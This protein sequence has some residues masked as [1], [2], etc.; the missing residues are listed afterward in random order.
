MTN[1]HTAPEQLLFVRMGM[2]FHEAR[3]YLDQQFK[4]VDLTRQEW[5]ILGW[6]RARPEGI[7]QAYAKAYIDV[8]TSYFTKL[9]NKLEDRNLITR[10]IDPKDRRNR[11]IKVKNKDA[12]AI[13]TVFNGI[14][15]INHYIEQDLTQDEVKVMNKC[16][17]KILNRLDEF[18]KENKYK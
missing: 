5:L 10:E 18:T 9:L 13:K 11:I 15:D 16:I 8:E 1:K 6:L 7:S 2:I 12:K 14:Y 17:D 4:A 3:Q